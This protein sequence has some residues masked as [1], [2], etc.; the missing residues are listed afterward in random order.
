MMVPGWGAESSLSHSGKV[1]S[2][3][4]LEGF[5]PCN[6]LQTAWPGRVE[7]TCLETYTELF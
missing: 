4:Y 6:L 1:A 2:L 7:V 5:P 3:V